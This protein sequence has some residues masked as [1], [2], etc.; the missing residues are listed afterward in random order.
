MLLNKYI[1]SMT[2][3]TKEK[4][5]HC[6][7][8]GNF[9]VSFQDEDNAIGFEQ[10][11]V[12]EQDKDFEYQQ[13]QLKMNYLKLQEEK[14]QCQE[15]KL[16]CQE[17]LLLYKKKTTAPKPIA[18]R[19]I[20]PDGRIQVRNVHDRQRIGTLIINYHNRTDPDTTFSSAAGDSRALKSC[21]CDQ[22]A[23]NVPRTSGSS[24]ASTCVLC[25]EDR[26]VT[27]KDKSV[28]YDKSPD[29]YVKSISTVTESVDLS[30]TD[31]KSEYSRY[32]KTTQVTKSV[33]SKSD[34][35]KVSETVTKQSDV[36]S[37]RITKLGRKSDVHC[38]YN[39]SEVCIDSDDETDETN[40]LI[41]LRNAD[42]MDVVDDKLKIV[43]A[44]SGYPKSK[45]RL[46]QM[47]V[48]QRSLNGVIDMQLKAGLMKRNPQFLDYYLNRGAI[49]CICKDVESRDWM[50]RITPGLQ[51]RMLDNL[52][53]LKAKVK[54]LCLAVIKIPKSCWPATAHDAFKLLQY[55]NPTLKTNL[56]KIYA[57]KVV[58]DVEITSFLVDRVS[59]EIIRGPNFKNVIDYN[60][61]EF[62]LTG[63]TEIYYECFLSDMDEDLSSV[64]S[65]VKLLEELRSAEVTPRN[66]SEN[67]NEK[68]G[69]E[70][71]S[72]SKINVNFEESTEEVIKTARNQKVEDKVVDVN[73][74]F[75][76]S[77]VKNTSNDV[78]L[79]LTEDTE[80]VNVLQANNNSCEEREIEKNEVNKPEV[81]LNEVN[82][83][84]A[85]VSDVTESIIESSENLVIGRN[86]NLNIDSNR[87]IAY[88]RR[89]NYLH[90]ENELKIAIVLEGYP[91]NKLE[92]THIRRLK[93]LFKEY[94][95]KDMKMQR[96][97]NMIIPK[98]QDIYLSNGAVIYICDSLETIDYLREILPKFV[99]NTGLK[100]IFKDVR[101]LV[102]YTRIVMKLPKELAHVAS[103]DI[104]LK[105]QEQY[106]KLKPDCWKHYSD[107]A[108]K[109][110]RQFGVEP[111]SLVVLKSADFDPTYDGE[112]L[113]FRIIDRQKPGINFEDSNV[114]EHKEEMESEEA[115]ELRDKIVKAM[116][117]AIEPGIM[118][119]P[120]T[121]R[122]A[123]H[124]SEVIADDFKLYV[125]PNNYPETRID[126]PMFFSIKKTIETIIF[127]AIYNGNDEF[128]PKIHDFYLFDGVIFIICQDMASRL[129]IERN[130][131]TMNTK[132]KGNLK[133]TEF[134]GAVGIISMFV[135]TDKG[136]DEVINILQTQNP[137]LRTKY[138]RKISTVKS[139]VK[140]DVVL[141]IDKLS[142]HVITDPK[143]NGKIGDSI[144]EFKLGHLK[145]LLGKKSLEELSKVKTK[146]QF[147]NNNNY[148][149]VET[150]NNAS[151]AL[152]A[153]D[154]LNITD[155]TIKDSE[156]EVFIEELKLNDGESRVFFYTG[157]DYRSTDRDSIRSY[158]Y[159]EE[160]EQGYCKVILKV[161][162]NILP[163]DGLDIIFDLLEDKNPGLNTELWKVEEQSEYNRGKFIVLVDKQS[164]SVIKGKDFDP[165]LGGEKLKFLF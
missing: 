103:R 58:D 89:T 100:L 69:L 54:R 110:K 74:Y 165:T 47:E 155:H 24:T 91:Q 118:N 7:N 159:I 131:P 41:V 120:L 107:V 31:Q 1:S 8:G 30:K 84:I 156:K 80:Q 128:I 113:S 68:N 75:G 108:G 18:S 63:Y 28:K 143:F 79:T 127:E 27:A 115:K 81:E 34:Y 147:T 10:G 25:S 70:K 130:I 162:T 6:A 97:S 134:R 14:L 109:Q 33:I 66:K 142:A 42:Y 51:E 29:K 149:K 9:D 146:K 135:K 163:D 144:A 56:W 71:E 148:K 60:Q 152:V 133:A 78:K 111:E 98:F 106:P 139:R 38:D 101:N 160:N 102:R 19:C 136:Y 53:L 62:E 93:H 145:S 105:L 21:S 73:E 44:L 94:L 112:K 59:G 164:A 20:L 129:W 150:K 4:L 49:V 138:W 52:V 153:Q 88:Y 86:S 37:K 32:S 87:G 64:A 43:V 36:T 114:T 5:D 92:G 17:A 35:S 83:S 61:M 22:S 57:Q 15:E 151:Q 26:S 140:L 13:L 123:N 65:R 3:S 161:P 77:N 126:E 50:V 125:G 137:R 90:V 67:V 16:Q 122:R 99:T 11:L 132:L 124:Y 45:M 121:K 55:F 141:Q 72:N 23:W 48:F 46:K 157:S 2:T 96:F 12:S 82:T 76:S 116:Y 95:H 117:C 119:A 154:N 85:A 39:Y 104:L 158:N 40:R